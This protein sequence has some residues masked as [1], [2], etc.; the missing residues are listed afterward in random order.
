[1][2]LTSKIHAEIVDRSDLRGSC[3]SM[4]IS[5]SGH[6]EGPFRTGG[7][8]STAPAGSFLSRRDVG[9]RPQV[10]AGRAEINSTFAV[11]LDHLRWA[12]GIQ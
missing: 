10:G 6:D 9:F 7:R 12:T 2:I 5:G 4:S 8:G 3:F 1:M 11:F